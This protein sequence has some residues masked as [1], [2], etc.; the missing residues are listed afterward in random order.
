[1]V[2]QIPKR[3]GARLRWP[4]KDQ[5][6][7]ASTVAAVQPLD[8]DRVRWVGLA[9]L[10]TRTHWRKTHR[11]DSQGNG[12]HPGFLALG[13]RLVRGWV[14][15]QGAEQ[16]CLVLEEVR[17]DRW[18]LD[19]RVVRLG[20]LLYFVRFVENHHCLVHGRGR[21][22][23]GGR[24]YRGPG[25]NDRGRPDIKRQRSHHD[26]VGERV[27]VIVMQRKRGIANG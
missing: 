18:Y 9:A 6:N 16:A 23:G 13:P 20:L 14:P 17:V 5:P 21:R 10:A 22:R 3:N 8:V 15:Q 7:W 12:P 26:V 27:V 1:M 24:K 11:L 25:Q 4:L 19:G 2:L